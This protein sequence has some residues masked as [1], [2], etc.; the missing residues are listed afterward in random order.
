[1]EG[2]FSRDPFWSCSLDYS[3]FCR[4]T[5]LLHSV[6]TTALF[7]TIPPPLFPQSMWPCICSFTWIPIFA[8][9]FWR[10][11]NDM[12][13]PKRQI[14]MRHKIMERS[15]WAR[16]EDLAIKVIGLELFF[17]RTMVSGGPWLQFLDSGFWLERGRL[18]FMLCKNHQAIKTTTSKQTI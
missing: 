7:S 12:F 8:R 17:F 14:F 1:M 15:L 3:L 5:D 6:S 11:F 16:H 10:N 9:F 2:D 13:S 4:N 18:P